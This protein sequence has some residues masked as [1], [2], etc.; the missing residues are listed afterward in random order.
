MDGLYQ[1]RCHHLFIQYFRHTPPP[2]HVVGDDDAKKEVTKVPEGFF[3]YITLTF[4]FCWFFFSWA[5]EGK[6]RRK[7]SVV[8]FFRLLYSEG[9]RSLFH[10][11]SHH[12][13][14]DIYFS[15]NKM[16]MFS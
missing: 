3:V 7:R 15:F 14:R 4:L 13:P 9:G 5:M 6:I 12:L 11:L 10:T 2:P 1:N 16:L 8:S